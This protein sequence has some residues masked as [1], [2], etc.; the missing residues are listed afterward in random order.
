L[1]SKQKTD[2]LDAKMK[3]LEEDNAQLKSTVGALKKELEDT[4]QKLKEVCSPMS[5]FLVYDYTMNPGAG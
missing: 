3:Q 5:P 4:K 1:H 2:E